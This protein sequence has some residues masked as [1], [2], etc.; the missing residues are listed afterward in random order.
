MKTLLTT[1]IL[2]ATFFSFNAFA[3]AGHDHIN[4][5]QAIKIAIKSAKQMTFK[6]FG[7]AVGKLDSS[8]KTLTE[9][10]V[11]I[12][13]EEDGNFFISANNASL[14][15]TIYFKVAQSGDLID[16]SNNSF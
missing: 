8:W 12:N 4:G 14:K 1:L 6:D 10:N 9:A 7:F 13:S 3:H 15:S 5:K 11:A 16:V 2:I